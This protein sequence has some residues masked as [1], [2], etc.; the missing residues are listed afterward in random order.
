MSIQ[1][2]MITMEGR[3]ESA[4][5]TAKQFRDLGIPVEIF[6]QPKDWPPGPP[7][8]NRNSARALSWFLEN[9]EKDN[10][11]LLFL[12]DDLEIKPERFKRALEEATQVGEITYLYMHEV[13]S[14]KDRYP[15]EDWVKS[16][17]SVRQ[18]RPKKFANEIKDLVA[19]EGLRPVTKSK[20]MYGAQCVLIPW[21]YVKFLLDEMTYAVEYT[22][23][24]K[25]Q[26]TR[27]VD[28]AINDFVLNHK[29]KTYVY[30][31]HPVQHLQNRTRR[32][33]A[34]AD[35]VSLSYHVRSDRE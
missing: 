19:P 7:S 22:Q 8:N 30:L 24:V 28:T 15:K 5:S 27:A 26:P 21:N 34:P 33:K 6:V 23:K 14:R 20:T 4:E 29:L 16:L 31:P 18:Y 9:R 35:R 17:F 13:L 25:A 1:A 32:K 3:E 2:V 10:T 12:E 11:H